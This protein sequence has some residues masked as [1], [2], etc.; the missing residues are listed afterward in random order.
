MGYCIITTKGDKM[1]NFTDFELT[2]IENAYE[3][4]GIILHDHGDEIDFDD[5]IEEAAYI[6]DLDDKMIKALK[7]QLFNADS[8]YHQ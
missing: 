4:V 6:H 5:A 7:A 1:K 3:E 2:A 8:P